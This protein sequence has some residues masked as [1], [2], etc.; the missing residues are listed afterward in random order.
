MDNKQTKNYTEIF[1]QAL[2]QR[3]NRHYYF[4]LYIAGMTPRSLRAIENI[5]KICD[6]YINGGYRLE[7]IDV[8]QQPGL[9]K[10]DNI[11]AVPTLVKI[12][13]TP[14]QRIVGDMSHTEEIVL[15]LDL[16]T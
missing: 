7:I 6:D 13:P 8:Y 5:K 1:E 11:V 2:A 3:D 10:K 4:R 12:L 15:E 14:L 16:L 9:G